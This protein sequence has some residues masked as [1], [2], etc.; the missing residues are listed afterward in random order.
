MPSVTSPLQLTV[1]ASM[2][3]NIGLKS[4]PAYLTAAI[5]QFNSTTAITNFTAALDYYKSR[6]WA[7]GS[8]MQSLLSIG[9]TSC[10]A[11]GNSIPAG[12]FD[13]TVGT[14]SYLS[15]LYLP[16][17]TDSEVVLNFANITQKGFSNYIYQT[18]AAYLGGDQPSSLLIWS[19]LQLSG[20]PYLRSTSTYYCDFLNYTGVWINTAQD[21]LFDVTVTVNFPVTGYYDFI[22]SCDNNGTIYVDGVSVLTI[23]NFLTTYTSSVYVTAGNHSLRLYGV[24]TGS[25]G[26]IGLTI[27]PAYL[28]NW[29][30]GKFSMGYIG[31]ESY[32]AI[33]NQYITSAANANQYLG[34]T[35][36]NTNDTVTAGISSMSTDLT[37]LGVDLAK[38]GNLWNMK[39]LDLY[40]TPAG[41]L[42]QISNVA[43]L[44]GQSVPE[45]QSALIAVGLTDVDVANLINDNRVGFNKPNGLSQN[46]FDRLQL[47]AY[48]ALTFS[49]ND[50]VQQVLDILDVTTPNINSLDDLLNPIIMFPLSYPSLQTPSPNGPIPIFNSAGAVNSNVQPVVNAYLPTASG[51]DELGKII[52]PSDAV[53]NK[54]IQVALQQI[55]GIPN[56]TLPDLANVI[57]G[58]VDNPWTPTQPYLA[59]AVVSNPVPAYYRAL[60]DIP[61]GTDINNPSWEPTTLGGLNTMAGLPLIQAQ[62]TP[63]D[64][65]VTAAFGPD[66]ITTYD[67]LGLAI[68]FFEFAPRLGL[69]DNVIWT[70]LELTGDPYITVSYVSYCDFLNAFGK[71]NYDVNYADFDHTVTVNFPRDGYYDFTGSVDNTA[72]IYIDGVSVL[73]MSTFVTTATNLVYV[74]AGDHSLRLYGI[75]TGSIGAIG[76]RIAYLDATAA[77][78]AL[79]TAGSLAT[80]NAAYTAILIAANDAQVITQIANANAAIDALGSDPYVTA[81]NQIWTYMA[82]LMNLSSQYTTEAGMDYF[83]LQPN[84]KSSI[85]SFVQNL[86]QY[87]LITSAQ[88]AC[89]FLNNIA[90]IKTLGGQAIVGSMREGQNNERLQKARLFNPTQI[91]S[92]PEVAPIPVI[93][94]VN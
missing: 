70:T 21:P 19:T 61:V 48:N 26:S 6:S 62:T 38:Q 71:W 39:K 5:Y 75:N 81:L 1:T 56:T 60:A 72:T 86:P 80:L 36:T 17:F 10:P 9:S 22:G 53:A 47:L 7:T 34:P 84:V 2:L 30:L 69:V 59:N 65:S 57:L 74:T 23:D 14:Y 76:L 29:D 15:S 93:V 79:Q 28:D 35:F 66:L 92:N 31:I 54:A 46:D 3:Q 67:V 52:P 78:N 73:S 94:P 24:N 45:L 88:N 40:G 18:A 87:G 42:Q 64:P 50:A 55:N 68:D 11:L 32:I 27:S 33:T 37:N 83:A 85:Y 91:P 51:C 4:V 12:P 25:L 13:S 58:N 82:D 90:N 77:I 89:E 49:S 20:A 44:R 43:G 41:L 16:S 8:T 63:V